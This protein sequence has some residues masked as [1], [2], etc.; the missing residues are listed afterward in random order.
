MH[1]LTVTKKY[2]IKK[3]LG[4]VAVTIVIFSA[5]FVFFTIGAAATSSLFFFF[6]R[7]FPVVLVEGLTISFG[8]SVEFMLEL[9]FLKVPKSRSKYDL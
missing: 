5:D 2:N 9:D 3:L 7:F 8:D 1:L 6:I 4:T